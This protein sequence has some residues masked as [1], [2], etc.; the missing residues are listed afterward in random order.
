MINKVILVGR[1]ANDPELRYTP[2][3][4]AVTRF[5]LAVN[6]NY[7]NQNGERE[8]DFI[9]I[10]AWRGLAEICANYLRKGSLAGV[11]GS[12]ETGKYTTNDGRNVRTVDVKA[13]N[14]QFLEPKG[15]REFM[16][17][18]AK[19]T[20]EHFGGGGALPDDPFAD[21]GQPINISDDD[22]PF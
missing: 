15:R 16:Q 1:L 14:V 5:T 11:V 12:I 4:V 18:E 3:G 8:A 19:K 20:Y 17:E 2:S 21:D 13:E 6:R 7:T 22:L 10:V 9:N